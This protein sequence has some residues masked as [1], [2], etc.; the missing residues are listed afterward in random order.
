MIK[1]KLTEI[2]LIIKKLNLKQNTRLLTSINLVHL[3]VN[4]HIS[5]LH[6]ELQCQHLN[7]QSTN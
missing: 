3:N 1:K 6:N 2:K 5:P 7:I 4:V